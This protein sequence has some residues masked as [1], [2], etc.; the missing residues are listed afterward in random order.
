MTPAPLRRVMISNFRRLVGS[1]EIPLD[2]PI[3]LIHGANGSGK[4]SL[5][6]GIELALT[7]EIRSMRRLDDRY[8]AHLP[9][10]GS[11]FATVGVELAD[12]D[13]GSQLP[14]R[15]T[16]GGDEIRGSPALDPERAQ[17]Y[18]ERVYLDQASLGQLLDLYQYTEGNQ[19]SALARFV[20]DLLGLDQLDALRTGL[21]D[22][23]DLRRLRNL[24]EFYADA[25]S[26]LKLAERSLD[27]ATGSLSSIQTELVG[28]RE[29]LQKALE[30]L[31]I[32]D[33]APDSDINLDEIETLIANDKRI[34]AL[35]ETDNLVT[36]L[37]ELR[38]RIRGIVAR[39]AAARLNEARAAVAATN[40]AAEQWRTSYE[41][42]IAALRS[43][44]ISLGIE[45]D[46]EI[47][48]SL[49]LEASALERR[50]AEH[51]SASSKMGVA[52]ENANKLQAQL[53]VV[54][55]N[56]SKAETRAGSLATGL[57]AL[58]NEI[59]GDHCP[60]CDRD[61]AEVSADHL[62]EHIDRK[63][64]DLASKGAEL[65]TLVD[66]RAELT[67][68]FRSAREELSTLGAV[69]LADEE[70]GAATARREALADLR[71]RLDELSDV[72]ARG[73]ELSTAVTDA[74]TALA[75]LEAEEQEYHAV[76]CKLA[77]HA[78][79]LGAA[80]PAV[81]ESLEVVWERLNEIAARRLENLNSR[82]RLLSGATE[83]VGRLRDTISRSEQLTAKIAGIAQSSQTWQRRIDE[84]NRRREIGR[85]VHTAASNTRAAIVERVFTQSLNDVWRDVFSR[86][87]P[88][89]PFVPAFG[90]PT[91]KRAALKLHLET[92]HKSGGS[93]GSPSMML[94]TGNLN[95]AALSLFIALH[96]AVESQFSC[97]VFDDPVQSMDEVHIAQFAGLLRMLCKRHG[98]QIVI[99]VHERELFEY[100]ALELSPAFEGDELITVELGLDS[101]G[102]PTHRATRHI[103]NDDA[104]L[105]I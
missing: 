7:G 31:K 16:V 71:R 104:A 5:L 102:C 72:I 33:V 40:A 27:E 44:V 62:V 24:S 58:R 34:R 88:S 21:H 100:L 89:E 2:A 53:E 15:I 98:R 13:G 55:A 65:Q 59:S 26:E 50:L 43:D 103:W 54:K 99:A 47:S 97:L 11:S 90:L 94:S 1:W 4:T 64:N 75:Q 86:L 74:A 35:P 101:E 95:T 69:I 51:K 39:P 23:T 68:L 87:A 79:A 73:A 46:R 80:A 37:I 3:V 22:A 66:Q 30:P 18:T 48:D 49:A 82:G 60:V 83:L 63:I 67:T 81:D 19:E 93:A 92:I 78:T 10:R 77:E 96:L 105:A 38:G 28:L 84:A 32:G 12:E 6:A 9:H 29:Q 17:F 14:P 25:E 91:T 36:D 41:A 45:I 76:T 56:I 70:F 61:F 52:V 20:N 8:T 57:A 85:A 42:P